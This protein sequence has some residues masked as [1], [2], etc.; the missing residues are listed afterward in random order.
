MAAATL[1]R[2]S[3]ATGPVSLSTRDTTETDTPAADATS[4]IVGAFFMKLPY[5]SAAMLASRAG[6]VSL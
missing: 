6:T 5:W 2:V 3:G 4:R 1:W